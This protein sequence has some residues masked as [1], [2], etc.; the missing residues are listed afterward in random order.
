M[1]GGGGLPLVEEKEGGPS[2]LSM[3]REWEDPLP[4]SLNRSLGVGFLF[5]MPAFGTVSY[6]NKTIPGARHR[7]VGF[8]NPTSPT[9][10]V[11]W[12]ALLISVEDK[13][14]L[15]IF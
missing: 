3:A 2:H 4:P 5:P 10:R 14:K 6:Q 9:F 12:H 13:V 7:G 11:G 8:E 1:G 15:L